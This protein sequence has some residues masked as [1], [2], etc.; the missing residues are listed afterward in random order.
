MASASGNNGNQ[1]LYREVNKRIRDMTAAA[2]G[3]V[4]FLCECG[5]LE[6]TAMVGFTHRQFDVLLGEPDCVLVAAEHAD[7]VNGRRT[8]AANGRYLVVAAG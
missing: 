4:E 1:R 3:P 2:D 8:L 6:C 5:Q 7:V